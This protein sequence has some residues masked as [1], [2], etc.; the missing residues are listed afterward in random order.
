MVNAFVAGF[1]DLRDSVVGSWQG[2]EMAV[3]DGGFGGPDVPCLQL[4]A[5]YTDTGTVIDT[6]QDDDVFGL[7][8]RPGTAV[9]VEEPGYRLRALTELP[10]GRVGSVTVHLDGD[11]LAEVRFRIGGQDLLLIAGEAHEDRSG[12]LVWHR[13]DESV[14]AFTDPGAADRMRWVPPRGPA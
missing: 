4:W 8:A 5:L 7:W 11:V 14:L 1:L 10:T 9:A 2:V 3:R 12:R 6:Y 13:L